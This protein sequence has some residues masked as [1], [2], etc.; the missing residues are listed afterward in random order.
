MSVKKSKQSNKELTPLEAVKRVKSAVNKL[1]NSYVEGRPVTITVVKETASDAR[2][3]LK[4]VESYVQVKMED[5]R[6]KN[7]TAGPQDTA[8]DASG[9]GY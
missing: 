1:A 6:I 8:E 9:N 2:K 7:M 4:I 5:D 3:M